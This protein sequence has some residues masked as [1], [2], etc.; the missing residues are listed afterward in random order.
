MGKPWKQTM[1]KKLSSIDMLS[2][3]LALW[4]VKK[5]HDWT[6]NFI[7]SWFKFNLR[8]KCY[9]WMTARLLRVCSAISSI[10]WSRYSAELEASWVACSHR[11]MSSIFD[12][13]SSTTSRVVLILGP[14]F[15]NFFLPKLMFSVRF[16][17]VIWG[18]Y[19]MS[20][21]HEDELSLVQWPI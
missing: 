12:H 8:D 3:N 20:L 2:W 21:H 14:I 5:S 9:L 17:R 19:R 7:S 4:L 16:R 10:L 6:S 18:P 15:S 11:S 1:S 13:N